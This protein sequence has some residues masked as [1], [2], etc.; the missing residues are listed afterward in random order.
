MNYTI[1]PPRAKVREWSV[2][3]ADELLAPAAQ[4]YWAFTQGPKGEVRWT[5]RLAD[6]AADRGESPNRLINFIRQHSRLIASFDD[7]AIP[8]LIV[9]SRTDI[10]VLDIAILNHMMAIERAQQQERRRQALADA[11]DEYCRLAVTPGTD[12]LWKILVC[13]ATDLH[14]LG[15]T[16]ND[17]RLTVQGDGYDVLR[18]TR[19]RSPLHAVSAPHTL[20]AH[21]DRK[22]GDFN[23][24]LLVYKPAELVIEGQTVP[25]SRQAF[26]A[27][28]QQLRTHEQLDDWYKPIIILARRAFLC[29]YLEDQLSRVDLPLP[30]YSSVD[31]SIHQLAERPVGFGIHAIWKTARQVLWHRTEHRMGIAAVL[32]MT[33]DR[34]HHFAS[35]RSEIDKPYSAFADG[36]TPLNAVVGYLFDQDS[37]AILG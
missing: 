19:Q 4:R 23:E 28:I 21:Q 36:L 16:A 26:D 10:A 1:D 3:C 37:V 15:Y 22:V 32:K 17:P 30:P 27:V 29:R 25:P 31:D 9:R 34:L 11:I 20:R 18:Q 2:E 13:Y 35:G 6:I 24:S 33:Q 8:P 14:R 7:P 5:E 12:E